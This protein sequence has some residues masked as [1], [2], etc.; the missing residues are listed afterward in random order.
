MTIINVAVLGGGPLAELTAQRVQS[1]PDLALIGLFDTPTAPPADTHCVLFLPADNET[2]TDQAPARIM[3]L[4]QAGFNVV[5]P[6]PAEGFPHTDLLAACKKGGSTFH[7]SGGYQS[8]LPTRFNRAFAA[9][10][11]DIRKVELTEEISVP[12]PA[13]FSTTSQETCY[14][15]A[16]HSLSEA[17]FCDR[18]TG[19]AVSSAV[20]E[21]TDTNSVTVFRSLGDNVVYATQWKSPTGDGAAL[22]YRLRTQSDEA[23]GITTISFNNV[24]DTLITDHL[25]C[26]GLLNAITAVFTSAPGILHHDLEINYVMPDDRL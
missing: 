14:N 21:S 19:E 7:G 2:T 22:R 6:I 26:N 15:G 16:L 11:R 4:L 23:T 18:M 13:D 5:S 1:R 9:I 24:S 12:N 8:N 20:A 3:T 10:T 25:A 17:V